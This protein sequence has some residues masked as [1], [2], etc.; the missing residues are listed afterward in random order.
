MIALA[1]LIALTLGIIVTFAMNPPTKT[2]T[3]EVAARRRARVHRA[4]QVRERAREQADR[5]R[6]EQSRGQSPEQAP[7]LTGDHGDTSPR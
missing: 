6:L 3:Y 7:S 4:A 1:I 5:Q 2:A